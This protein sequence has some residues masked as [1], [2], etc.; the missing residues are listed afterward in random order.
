MKK[1]LSILMVFLLVVAWYT[2]LNTWLGNDD[3]YQEYLEEAKRLEEK[4][5]YLDAISVYGQAA[6]LKKDA[7][8]LDERIADDYLAMGDYKQYQ[9]QLNKILA[10]HGPVDA[11]VRKLCEY[12]QKYSSKNRLI[13]CVVDLYAKYPDSDTVLEYYNL[14][15][16]EY[17]ELPLSLSGIGTFR[18]G[19]AVYELNGKQ[20]II[21]QDGDIVIEAVYDETAYGGQE[22]RIT[23]R[24]KNGCYFV[25]LDGFKT[26]VPES[27]YEWLGAVSQKRIAARRN[28][29][30]G[31][32]DSSLKE[33]IEFIYDD[34]TAFCEDVAAVKQGDKWALIDR[35]GENITDYIYDDVAVNSLGMCSVNGVI[36]V[37]QGDAWIFVNGEGEQIGTNTFQDIKAFESEEPCAVQ[38]ENKWSYADAEGNIVLEC[39]YQ[40]AAPFSEG[41]APVCRN[42][43]WGYI[44][45]NGY[46][47][48]ACA[49][50]Q[51]GQMTEDGTA[52]VSRSGSWTLIRLEVMD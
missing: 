24:D 25:N 9:K 3:R 18:N 50:D 6:E 46:E 16:G 39:D 37:K 47:A 22:D 27:D 5:L 4:G 17:R 51:A 29:K 26:A 23:V 15:K 20:G 34:A 13:D 19:Y 8:E 41:F 52:P 42:G 43:L 49:F 14:I 45:L 21:E 48:V 40:D 12:H 35:M 36:G 38:T 10:D 28:G 2:T 7:L 44:D 32:L 33:K 30:Y 31:Y 1:T 11:D